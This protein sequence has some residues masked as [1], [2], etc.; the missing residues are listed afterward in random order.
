M[1][2]LKDND[3]L[4]IQRQ[5][6]ELT[7]AANAHADLTAVIIAPSEEVTRAKLI[8]AQHRTDRRAKLIDPCELAAEEYDHLQE[9]GYMTG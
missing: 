9:E 4:V 1:R 5:R 3:K 6:Q 8:E 2:E 7:Y